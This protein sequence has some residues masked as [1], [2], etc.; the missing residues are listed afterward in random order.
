M[1]RPTRAARMHDPRAAAGTR[2]RRAVPPALLDRAPALSPAATPAAD[3]AAPRSRRARWPDALGVAAVLLLTIV[4]AWRL[5]RGGTM[6]GLDSVAFF[7]PMWHFLGTQ[8]RAFHVPGWNPYQFSG[9]PFAGDPESGWM[10]LPA[11]LLFALLPLQ[12]AAKAFIVFHLL[13]AGLGT[14][15]LARVLRLTAVGALV[16]AVAFEFSGFFYDRSA[17]CPAHIEVAA[18]L[19]L[20]L[21]G[22][23]LAIRARSWPS[24]ALWWEWSGFCLS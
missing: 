13:L 12:L 2:L 17:C 14:Y 4:G 8:I 6:I 15:A 9:V 5:V 10:Y 24:R 21:L 7:Y 20:L 1:G 23:E 22:A 3:R 11:M 18:W 16:A 19:P